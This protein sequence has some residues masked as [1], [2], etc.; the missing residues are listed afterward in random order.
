MNEIYD[1]NMEGVKLRWMPVDVQKKIRAH[2]LFSSPAKK[3]AF[4]NQNFVFGWNKK[5]KFADSLN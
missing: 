3:L 2:W 1:I 4:F 5:C